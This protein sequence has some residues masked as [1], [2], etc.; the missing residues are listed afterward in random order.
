MPVK[1]IGHW[2]GQIPIC[3]SRKPIPHCPSEAIE[4]LD[5]LPPRF[6]K[7]SFTA[8][9]QYCS[10]RSSISSTFSPESTFVWLIEPNYLFT[11]SQPPFI[12]GCCL[13]KVTVNFCVVLTSVLF[14]LRSCLSSVV[15]SDWVVQLEV[16][17]WMTCV[18]DDI[19]AYLWI[20][21]LLFKHLCFKQYMMNAL[22]LCYSCKVS[23]LTLVCLINNQYFTYGQKTLCA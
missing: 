5:T 9:L 1:H 12:W 10:N 23:N 14:Q 17:Y 22:W 11:C 6:S 4:M 18:V 8:C 3:A 21:V 15:F 16:L 2:R 13:W 7:C 20:A 19:H